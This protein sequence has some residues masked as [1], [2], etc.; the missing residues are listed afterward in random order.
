MAED[1]SLKY[2]KLPGRS[3]RR[4]DCATFRH[5]GVRKVTRRVERIITLLDKVMSIN[6]I[7]SSSRMKLIYNYD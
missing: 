1:I 5:D 4:A 2:V 7:T 6:E 3:G